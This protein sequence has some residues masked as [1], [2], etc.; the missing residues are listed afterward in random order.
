M[1]LALEL[2]SAVQDKEEDIQPGDCDVVYCHRVWQR[3]MHSLLILEGLCRSLLE[4]TIG[5]AGPS[6]SPPYQWHALG[7]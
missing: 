4:C 7:R 1:L 3:M 6:S 5:Q 2:V